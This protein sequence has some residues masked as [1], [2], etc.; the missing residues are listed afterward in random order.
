MIGENLTPRSPTHKK[1]IQSN[2]AKQ[3]L[4]EILDGASLDSLA[5]DYIETTFFSDLYILDR[6]LGAG[7]FGVV[8]QVI[9]RATCEEYAM[10]VLLCLHHS[11]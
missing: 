3:K 4:R 2:R 6:V 9:E 1:V 11:S 10:K 5:L 8:L 7:T